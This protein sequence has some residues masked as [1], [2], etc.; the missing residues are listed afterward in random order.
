[1]KLFII[2][3]ALISKVEKRWEKLLR[4]SINWGFIFSKKVG[5]I[6]VNAIILV[7]GRRVQVLLEVLGVIVVN[8]FIRICRSLLP[9]APFAPVYWLLKLFSEVV[10]VVQLLVIRFLRL[11]TQLIFLQHFLGF[12]VDLFK[13]LLPWLT[14]R[15]ILPM[16]VLLL[17]AFCLVFDDPS[18]RVADP[19]TDGLF[20]MV[21]FVI[22]FHLNPGND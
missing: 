7:L 12:L 10:H 22:F 8:L 15:A 6:K 5:P 13:L 11:F 17:Y 20:E 21:C 3:S 14:A 16:R 19:G 18:G 4:R 9:H 2:S 1:M